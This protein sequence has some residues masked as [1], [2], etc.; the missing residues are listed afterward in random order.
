MNRLALLILLVV[1]GAS[2][3]GMAIAQDTLLRARIGHAAI[4]AGLPLDPFAWRVLLLVAC[5]PSAS[6]VVLLAERYGA[7][8]GRIALII[9]LSTALSFLTFSAAVTF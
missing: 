1:A 9:L 7:D 8:T 6:N 3:L 5:L 4:A 2:V